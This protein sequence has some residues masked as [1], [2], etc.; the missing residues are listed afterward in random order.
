MSENTT[1]P[2]FKLRYGN[3]SA[4][5]WLR[6]TASAGYFYDTTF[7]RVFAGRTAIGAIPLP[8]KTGTCPIWRKRQRTFIPGSTSRRPTPSRSMAANQRSNEAAAEM[9]RPAGQPA[10]SGRRKTPSQNLCV[11][12]PAV[13]PSAMITPLA[14]K[15]NLIQHAFPGTTLAQRCDSCLPLS[16]ASARDPPVARD[17]HIHFPRAHP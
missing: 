17:F 4:A 15:N 1:K 3:V 10:V 6:N 2:V 16:I 11:A 7:T 14:E 8:L 5:V 12:F 9:P 13:L